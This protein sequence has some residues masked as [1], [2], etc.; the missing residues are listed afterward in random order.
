LTRRDEN[1]GPAIVLEQII[2]QQN[3]FV[4]GQR[5]KI[6]RTARESGHVGLPFGAGAIDAIQDCGDEIV[7]IP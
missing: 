3:D 2:A 5:D 6:V 7:R 4:I 1:A